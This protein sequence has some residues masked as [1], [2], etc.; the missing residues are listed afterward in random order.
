VEDHI[1]PRGDPSDQRRVADVAAHRVDFGPRR[2]R[3]VVDPAERVERV[4]VAERGYVALV[5]T[6]ASTRCEPM[7]PSAPVTRTFNPAYGRAT[8]ASVTAI[9]P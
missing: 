5:R 7:K 2:P 8:G 1:L 3:K 4:V 9:L 6:S